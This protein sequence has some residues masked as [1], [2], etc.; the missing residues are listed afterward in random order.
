MTDRGEPWWR[1]LSAVLVDPV[2]AFR[3]AVSRPAP[4]LT[5]TVLAAATTAFGLATLPRQ[6]RVLGRGL[7]FTGDALIDAQHEALRDM[8]TRL[9]VIDRLVPQPTV[10]VAA[11][12]VLLA[13]E[14]VLMLARDRRRAIL[15]VVVLG[16]APLVLER[17]GELAISYLLSPASRPTPG[18]AMTIPHRFV[19]G[20]AVFW[21]GADSV[22]QWLEVLDARINLVSL[23]C[24]A[25]WSVG[26]RQLDGRQWEPWHVVLP[27]G[28]LIGSGLITWALTPAVIPV[29]M[30]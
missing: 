2:G 21:H 10:I 18:W 12:L 14:P 5:L 22:P 23:G 6:L 16:L 17:V 7:P 13:A 25:L 15:A 24:V 9:I 19:T 1:P 4:G 3:A 20:P 8:V 28:C 26:I 11:A 27:V 30:Q 29:L